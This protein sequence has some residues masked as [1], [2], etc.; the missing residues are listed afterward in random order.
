MK[1]IYLVLAL[2]L[3]TFSTNAQDIPKAT[4]DANGITL[5]IPYFEL[6]TPDGTVAYKI[7]LISPPGNAEFP[8]FIDWASF[9]AVPLATLPIT[10]DTPATPTA[11]E[12]C[13]NSSYLSYTFIADSQ[14]IDACQLAFKVLT[15]T[16]LTYIAGEP[17]QI[18]D[19]VD[20][21]ILNNIKKLARNLQLQTSDTALKSD[22]EQWLLMNP[23]VGNLESIIGD[24]RV[25]LTD[26]L[27]YMQAA[28][29][30]VLSGIDITT[31]SAGDATLFANALNE[32]YAF[33]NQ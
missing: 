8:F 13:K 6:E 9:Q 12:L 28:F 23:G 24:T 21:N 32:M 20:T 17:Q 4:I 16:T 31:F 15:N 30:M 1:N 2:M 33:L 26:Q 3:F 11:T 18:G 22:I 5:N 14:T 25:L 27:R 29:L 7:T 10:T 19:E